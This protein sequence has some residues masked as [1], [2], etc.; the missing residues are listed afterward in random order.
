MLT[1]GGLRGG[2][3][4]DGRI[5]WLAQS[6]LIEVAARELA[7]NCYGLHLAARVDVRDA[8][9]LAYL[10]LASRK[11]GDALANLARYARGPHQPRSDPSA[12]HGR[13]SPR[14]CVSNVSGASL[15]VTTCFISDA[16]EAARRGELTV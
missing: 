8:D 12:G 2:N 6:S 4:E 11:F 9:V 3:R 15:F 13:R 14:A 7:D 5:P 10:G 1:W 16:V